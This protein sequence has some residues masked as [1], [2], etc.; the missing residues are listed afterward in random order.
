MKEYEI[1]IIGAS[2]TGSALA[3][4]LGNHGINVCLIDKHEFPRRKPCGEGLSGI[5]EEYLKKLNLSW[6]FN[7]RDESSVPY[8]PLNG[9]GIKIRNLRFHLPPFGHRQG[10]ARGLERISLDHAVFQAATKHVSVT[11]IL[12]TK[13]SEIDPVTGIISGE[14]FKIKANHIIL[15]AG[16]NHPLKEDQK[17]DSKLDRYGLSL[18]CRSTIPHKLSTVEIFVFRKLQLFVTPV[19]NYR[20]NISALGS[21]ENIKKLA[22]E[23]MTPAITHVAQSLDLHLTP[24]T[25]LM[26]AGPFGGKSTT[27]RIGKVILAGDSYHSLDPIGGMGM[28][29]ALITAFNLGNTLVEITE[30]NINPDTAFANLDKTMENETVKIRVFTKLAQVGLNSILSLVAPTIKQQDPFTKP[31]PSPAT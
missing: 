10:T 19:T 21:R 31:T 3:Y 4:T 24:S 8:I 14:N 7:E 25:P 13:I 12:N 30:R 6:I 22:H 1:A 9:Y 27:R 17:L 18:H 16:P 15:A 29:Q 28:T 5:G 2:L 11:P 23:D 20:L 26:G